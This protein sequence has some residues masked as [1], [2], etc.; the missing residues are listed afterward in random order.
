MEDED[1]STASGAAS[2]AVSKRPDRAAVVYFL[3]AGGVDFST[4]QVDIYRRQLKMLR[5]EETADAT[6][7]THIVT[8]ATCSV[9]A[10]VASLRRFI[11]SLALCTTWPLLSPLLRPSTLLLS[12]TWLQRCLKA[13]SMLEPVGDEVIAAAAGGSACTAVEVDSPPSTSASP[14]PSHS[15]STAA[16]DLNS[17][18][19]SCVTDFPIAPHLPPLPQPE[20]VRLQP[21]VWYTTCATD[22]NSVHVPPPDFIS[23]HDFAMRPFLHASATPRTGR[24]AA[25][26]NL[27]PSALGVCH[28]YSSV[29]LKSSARVAAFDLDGTLIVPHGKAKFCATASDFT[30]AFGSVTSTLRRL[31]AAGFKLVIFTN[32]AGVSGG[33]TTIDIVRARVE[34]VIAA[35]GLPMQAFVATHSDAYRKPFLGMVFLLS[36]R[37]NEGVQIDLANSVFVGDAAARIKTSLHGKDHS[38][39]DMYMAMNTGMRFVTPEALFMRA[40]GRVDTHPHEA[41]AS[42]FTPSR[43]IPSPYD[44]LPGAGEGAVQIALMDAATGVRINPEGAPV[45]LLLLVALPASGKS[46][47]CTLAFPQHARVNQDQLKTRAACMAAARTHLRACTSV[48]VDATNIDDSVR[49][50]WAALAREQHVRVRALVIRPNVDLSLHLDAVRVANPLGGVD[51]PG[52]RRHVPEMVIRGMMKR[53]TLPNASMFDALHTIVFRPGPFN[54]GSPADAM[55]RAFIYGFS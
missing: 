23:Q 39:S 7:C 37:C 1:D 14:P 47:L 32:Q 53:W 55:Q 13:H 27:T 26:Y 18:W 48:I 50:E 44:A 45:E 2:A 52:D 41:V 16:S 3:R 24:D 33:K 35:V 38:G 4:A 25:Y 6:A 21:G 36:A 12:H 49:A 40:S 54:A 28:V 19:P 46:T 9:D 31:H 30:L 10:A 51:G 43:D 11:P 42:L 5:M 15:S 29:G 34:A 8:S 17:N 20:P 22:L